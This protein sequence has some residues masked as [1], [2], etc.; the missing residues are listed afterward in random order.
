[1]SPNASVIYEN[2]IVRLQSLVSQF[3]NLH[4]VTNESSKNNSSKS[5]GEYQFFERG[6]AGNENT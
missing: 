2:S 1:M 6:N 3:E 5:H 4:T